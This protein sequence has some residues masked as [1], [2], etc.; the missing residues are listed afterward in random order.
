MTIPIEL[1]N[2][3][4]QFEE[5]NPEAR[6]IFLD[7]VEF[8]AELIRLEYEGHRASNDFEKMSTSMEIDKAAVLSYQ[9]LLLLHDRTAFDEMEAT[10][11]LLA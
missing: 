10:K 1:L 7:I 2:L 3:V 6:K 9:I 8:A 5:V 11:P 4:E